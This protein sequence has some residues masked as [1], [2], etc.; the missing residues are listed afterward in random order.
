MTQGHSDA[1]GSPRFLTLLLTVASVWYIAFFLVVALLRA[2]FPMQLEWIEGGV[3]DA[4]ARAVA[5]QPIYV[6]PT[7]LFVPYLYTPLYYYVGALVCRIAGVGFT[8]LRLLSTACTAGCCALLFAQTRGLTA[9]RRAGLIA[10]GCFAGLY[11]AAGGCYDLAR[12]DMLFLLLALAAIYAVWRRQPV[13]AGM[14][15]ACAYQSKQGAAIIAICVLAGT[16]RR[17]R[18]CITGMLAFLIPAGASTLWL[19]HTSGGWYSFYTQWL[20]S[21]HPLEP[22]SIFF[23]FARDLARYLL[24]ALVLI[25]WTARGHLRQL[26]SSSHGNFLFSCT[27]GVFFT[28]FFGRIHSGGAANATLPLYAWIA[29]LFGVA[30][31]RGGADSAFSAVRESPRRAAVS[32]SVHDAVALSSI[33]AGAPAGTAVSRADLRDTG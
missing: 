28:A 14:L 1:T 8:P 5:H 17:T 33:P 7:H 22:R 12:V 6:A 16:W 18:Q 10:A 23:F 27:L 11:A 25:A 2:N 29:V 31:H 26:W 32:L 15:F 9:S 4:V 20:P 24:P 21:H 13:L 30:L 3:L 19:N